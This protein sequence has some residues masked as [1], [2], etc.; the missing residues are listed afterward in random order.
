MR[1]VPTGNSSGGAGRLLFLLLASQNPDRAAARGTDRYGN[2]ASDV[3]TGQG[4]A[5]NPY[6]AARHRQKQQQPPKG[7]PRQSN[8]NNSSNNGKEDVNQPVISGERA[9]MASRYSNSFSAFGDTV[10][11][12]R[13]AQAVAAAPLHPAQSLL[14][15]APRPDD[16]EDDDDM[17]GAQTTSTSSSIDMSAVRIVTRRGGVQKPP[18]Y[19]GKKT[20]KRKTNTKPLAKLIT[21]HQ[22]TSGGSKA[23]NRPPRSR[24]NQVAATTATKPPPT[25]PIPPSASS[26]ASKGVPQPVISG[27]RASMASRYTNSPSP[28]T[29]PR[30][31]HPRVRPSRPAPGSWSGR[32]GRLQHLELLVLVLPVVVGAVLLA[33]VE[34]EV[35]LPVVVQVEVQL[36]LMG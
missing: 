36:Q 25:K 27:E 5:A 13:Q 11:Q 23:D 22:Q 15:T 12:P 18:G 3:V 34:E 20:K 14:E 31:R 33:V 4:A 35:D 1:V 17:L 8:I 32:C 26:S 16:D 29:A 28:P 9:S 19:V 21:N 2:A 30:R 24:P 7:V 6:D 10:Q